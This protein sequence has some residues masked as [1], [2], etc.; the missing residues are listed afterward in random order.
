MKAA[1]IAGC[2]VLSVSFGA[3]GAHATADGC[4]VVLKT[5]DGFLNVRSQP[6][7][8]SRILKRFKPGEIID[9]DLISEDFRW[10]RVWVSRKKDGNPLWGWV[11]N[12]FIIGVDC[13]ETERK[14]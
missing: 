8:K 12:R 9:T 1:I 10:E 7:V 4:A 5:P 13:E 6:T 11:R 2:V 14:L 3:S